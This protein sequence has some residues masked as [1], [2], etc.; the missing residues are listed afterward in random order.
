[1]QY[2]SMIGFLILNIFHSWPTNRLTLLFQGIFNRT[3]P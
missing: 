1:V 3:Y 2:I